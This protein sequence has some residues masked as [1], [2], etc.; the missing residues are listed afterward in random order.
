MY[1]GDRLR[2][3]DESK[4]GLEWYDSFFIFSMG[5]DNK[6]LYLLLAFFSRKK[7]KVSFFTDFPPQV[8]LYF[9]R[10]SNIRTLYFDYNIKIRSPLIMTRYNYKSSLKP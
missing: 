2:Y 4:K 6:T 10:F 1:L 5:F 7:F 8:F 9:L 3:L